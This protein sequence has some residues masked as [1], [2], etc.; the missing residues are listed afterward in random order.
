MEGMGEQMRR[1]V[2]VG[3]SAFEN[4]AFLKCYLRAD[5]YVIAADG[6]LRLLDAMEIAPHAIIGD[7]DSSPC[8]DGVTV[9]VRRLPTHKD[10]TDVFAAAKE[11]LTLGYR[12]FLLLGCLGGRLDHTLSNLFLLRFLH[13]NNARGLLADEHHEVS[14]LASGEHTVPHRDNCFFSLLPFGGDAC[15]V[16]I[17]D[18]EY[19]LENATLD[20]V[21][22]LGVSNGFLSS[23]VTVSLQDGYLLLILAQ[24]DG[25]TSF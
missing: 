1:C 22:P 25:V 21:F 9:P 12:E 3:A 17:R 18:A 24:K 16:T 20:T 11:A 6:G 10:D 23:D 4:A 13:E 2:I 7:F 19:P 5:D 14:L 8:P 15:G